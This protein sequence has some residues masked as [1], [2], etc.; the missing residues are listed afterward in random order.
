MKIIK[1]FFGVICYLFSAI[2]AL[3]CFG[4][5]L[6]L[7]MPQQTTDIAILLFG[8]VIEFCILV[9]LSGGLW[10]AGE[11]LTKKEE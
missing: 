5:V 10:K 3:G 7:F 6:R 1:Y 2:F 8:F 9:A 11:F 4:V